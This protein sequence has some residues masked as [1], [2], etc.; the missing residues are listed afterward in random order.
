LTEYGLAPINSDPSFTVAAT[1]GAVGTS[2]WLAPEI[3]TPTRKGSG[4]PVVES[5]AADVFAFG[6][7]AVEVFTGKIPFEDQKNEAVVLRISRGGRPEMPGD[8]QAVGL[9]DEMWKV[10]ESCWQQNPK[11]RPTMEEVVRRWQR[12]VESNGDT[13]DVTKGPPPAARLTPRQRA[14]TEAAKPPPRIDTGRSRR[15]SGFVPPRNNSRALRIRTTSEAVRQVA[16]FEVVQRSTTPEIVQGTQVVDPPLTP[17]CGKFSCGLEMFTGNNGGKK[18][19]IESPPPAARLTPR[20][21]AM[22]EAAQ[23]PP[24]TETDRSRTKSETTPPQTKPEPIPPQTKPGTSRFRTTSEVARPATWVVEP[25]AN[26]TDAAIPN[27]T[28]H[29]C[30][31]F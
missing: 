5:K 8:A 21:R 4:M 10:L 11:R 17:T 26:T 15:K 30:G 23:P 19:V 14:R 25:S 2:R 13:N 16:V 22:T 18:G 6:M 9:T 7:F 1:P 3:I 31:L 27:Y 12:F 28:K 24:R 20:Q 29:F